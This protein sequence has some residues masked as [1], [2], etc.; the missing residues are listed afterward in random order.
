MKRPW[1]SLFLIVL[2]M[3]AGARAAFAQTPSFPACAN[4]G[5][6]LNQF[7]VCEVVMQQTLYTDEGQAYTVPTVKGV[8][9]HKKR[10]HRPVRQA[11]DGVRLL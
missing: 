2:T 6:A 8:F 5:L 3:A 10:R 7:S 1:R 9:K 4:G 11:T